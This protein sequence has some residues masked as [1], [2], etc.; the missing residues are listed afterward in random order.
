MLRGYKTKEVKVTI[1]GSIW[2]DCI[3]KSVLT[4]FY[5]TEIFTYLKKALFEYHEDGKNYLEHLMP[6]KN[7]AYA[8]FEIENFGRIGIAICKDLLEPDI[9]NMLK[10]INVNFLCVPAYSP[11]TDLH[12]EARELAE[13]TG[14]ITVMVNSCGALD[15]NKDEIGFVC[16]PAKEDDSRSSIMKTFHNN[17]CH[18]DCT[19]GCVGNIFKIHLDDFF[20]Y[21]N[22]S[23]FL[24]S[25][26][27]VKNEST[28]DFRKQ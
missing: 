6:E 22:K 4:D 16:M 15:N 25:E 3:N 18:H 14:C 13:Q 23:S 1:N 2:K 10:K 28:T 9:R 26:E 20:M 12:S 5:G 24:I 11:S 27:G 21:D 19:T 7:K 8:V 17:C